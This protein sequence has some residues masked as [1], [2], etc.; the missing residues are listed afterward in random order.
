[1]GLVRQMVLIRRPCYRKTRPSA[2]P[3]H[4]V[5]HLVS[6]ASPANVSQMKQV[7][8][9]EEQIA[10]CSLEM[11]VSKT[12]NAVYWLTRRRISEMNCC[13]LVFNR[14]KPQLLNAASEFLLLS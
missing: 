13:K 10:S 1:M 6:T 8:A 4:I 9:N 11:R 14:T 7:F 3:D 12:H 2:S 5:I